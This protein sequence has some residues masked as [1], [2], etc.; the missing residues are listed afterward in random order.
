MY[1]LEKRKMNAFGSLNANMRLKIWNNM[2]RNQTGYCVKIGNSLGKNIQ[3]TMPKRVEKATTLD[4]YKEFVKVEGTS[5]SNIQ[6]V[7][8]INMYRSLVLWLVEFWFA[9]KY[10]YTKY[11]MC[12]PSSYY[13]VDIWSVTLQTGL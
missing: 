12:F 11:G 9:K 3:Q 13:T 10:N 7:R 6:Y 5:H 8:S 1:N 4:S 2:F